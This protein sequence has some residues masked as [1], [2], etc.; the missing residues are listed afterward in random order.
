MVCMAPK[1]ST[2]T[3]QVAARAYIFDKDNRI[4]LV[5]MTDGENAWTV[6]RSNVAFGE[7]ILDVAKHAALEQAGID[8]H[9]IGTLAVK[10][11]LADP[12]AGHAVFFEI[13]CYTV[14]D[15]TKPACT[16]ECRW[17]ALDGAMKA[18]A[19]N[20]VRSLIAYYAKQND[21]GDIRL[22]NI[23]ME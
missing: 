23:G 14:K 15:Y 7:H 16:K 19:S 10:E 12:E 1:A 21:S 5:R 11:D 3:P 13:V 20:E 2:K 17:F 6:P 18:V 4:L 9:P 22:L 8:V